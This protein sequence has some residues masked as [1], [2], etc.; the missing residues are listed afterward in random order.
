MNN[1]KTAIVA[2]ELDEISLVGSGDDPTAHML[3]SK[4]REKNT[5]DDQGADTLQDQHA[6][7]E[8]DGMGVINKDDLDPEVAEYIDGLEEIAKGVLGLDDDNLD[9]DEDETI[10]EADDDGSDD[11]TEAILKA[12]PALAEIVSKARADA[13]E[14]ISKA[15]A[16]EAAA[17]RSEAISKAQAL[18]HIQGE[19]DELA[20]VLQAI[21]K[22]DPELSK[23]VEKLLTAANA[24]IAASP[25]FSEI[26]KDIGPSDE[27]AAKAAEIKKAHPEFTDEAA[28]SAV[29]EANPDLYAKALREGNI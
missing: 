29:Y 1:K 19:R 13:A 7:P 22:A 3:I 20:D 6:D 11:D 12:N 23:Q 27:I 18:P 4:A 15:Q 14:A 16:L 17:E 28:I 24:A 25:L 9:D 10:E 8:D 5:G 2:M 21:A 26:G